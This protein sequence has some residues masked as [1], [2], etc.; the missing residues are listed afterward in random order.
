MHEPVRRH[1]DL[2]AG[3]SHADATR[4]ARH[5]H[6]GCWPGGGDRSEPAALEWV[7]RWAP[8]TRAAPSPV[9]SCAHGCCAICN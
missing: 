7:R 3:R 1:I 2:I 4:L 9:C 8:A 5:L 6:D